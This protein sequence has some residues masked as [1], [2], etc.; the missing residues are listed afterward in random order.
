MKTG[1]IRT[2]LLSK[3][4]DAGNI[5]FLTLL[6]V[7][8]I[9]PFLFLLS[10]SFSPGD[11]SFSQIHLIPPKW[12][13]SNY[14]KV[15]TNEF[16]ASG[17][18]NTLLRTLLGTAITVLITIF[19][20]YPLSKK[21]FPNRNFWTAFIVFTMFF[22]GGLIPMY[23]LVKKLGMM[24]SIWALI[25]PGLV[26]TFQMIIARNFFMS[27]PESL[28]E[29]AK[30]DGA[31]EVR[32]LFSLVIPLSMPIIATLS[33][34]TAVHHWNAWFDSMIYISDSNKHV[35]QVVLRRIV[36]EGTKDMMDLNA[37]ENDKDMVANPETIKATTVMVAT[38]PIILIY[39]FVQK[40]F[41]KGIMVG[42]LKG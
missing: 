33:L 13:L 34:W 38:I 10:L 2:S 18:A 24:N 14:E 1:R 6:C 11:I 22:S 19:T 7:A 12:T 29:S 35:L 25:I 16:I 21:Y 9:Y 41:V 32:I 23:L 20:A 5:V 42:S 15:L 31:N 28:E 36:L 40:H 8:T 37:F 3:C 4:F 17:F 27:L 39:P 30:I 26:H